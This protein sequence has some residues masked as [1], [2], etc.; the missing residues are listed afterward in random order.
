MCVFFKKIFLA[1][2]YFIGQRCT[3]P[4]SSYPSKHSPHFL[5]AGVAVTTHTKYVLHLSRWNFICGV[6]SDNILL[7]LLSCFVGRWCSLL[8]DFPFA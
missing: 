3:L 4:A 7:L 1:Y 6:T 2:F 5:S 8:A